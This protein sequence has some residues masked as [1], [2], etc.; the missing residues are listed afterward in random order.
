MAVSRWLALLA[1]AWCPL[2]ALAQ[3]YTNSASITIPT[4]GKAATYPSTIAVAGG[5]ASI[6]SVVVTL[7]NLT[8]ARTTDLDILLVGPTG[9]GCVL[10]SDVGTTGA[11][12]GLSVS[13]TPSSRALVTGEALTSGAFLPTN[14]GSGE[15]LP[16]PAPQT[17][18]GSDLA[19]FNSTNAN[20]TWSLFIND[21][22]SGAAG[23]SLSGGWSIRFNE[24]SLESAQSPTPFRYQGRLEVG[25][26]AF[27]GNAD[28]RFSLWNDSASTNPGVQFGPSLTQNSVS[29]TEG[30]F[31]T[32]LDF[33]AGSFDGVRRFLQIDARAPAGSG[34]FVT[35]AGRTEVMPT[36]VAQYAA[37]SQ[38]AAVASASTLATAATQLDAPDGAPTSAVSVL[39]SGAVVVPSSLTVQGGIVLP[40][41]TRTRVIAPAAWRPITNSTNF[42]SGSLGESVRSTGVLTVFLMPIDIPEG[43]VL[44]G[45]TAFFID[46][47]PNDVTFDIRRAST[48]MVPPPGGTVV[49]SSGASPLGR[50]IDFP[51]L[52]IPFDANESLYI[53][54]YLTGSA[55]ELGA[56]RITYTITS[57]LP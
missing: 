2:T 41:T 46:N 42:S 26:K 6:T 45:I 17:A 13:L 28:F 12:A 49:T 55:T 35:L 27:S 11:V 36:P 30:V 51:P 53:T 40:T 50:S 4:S 25:G 15:I 47:G 3:V 32:T 14:I 43:A 21:D 9:V 7:N 38:S 5:P 31:T 24:S 8:H 18:F 1:G 33:G 34:S 19:G 10:L 29:V 39:N 22:S 23:G 52:N 57:P 44:T 20:G 54:G 37:F 48:S 16:T 56:V